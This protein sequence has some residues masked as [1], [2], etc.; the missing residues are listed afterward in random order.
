MRSTFSTNNLDKCRKNRLNVGGENEKKIN[1]VDVRDQPWDKFRF[2]I[3]ITWFATGL[4]NELET[5]VVTLK[6]VKRMF[7]LCDDRVRFKRKVLTPLVDE[8]LGKSFVITVT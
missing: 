8:G 7:W 4:L 6:S 5:T 2:Y 1:R 3:V